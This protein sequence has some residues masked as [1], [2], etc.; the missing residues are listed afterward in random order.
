MEQE[1]IKCACGSNIQK[2]SLQAH[3]KSKKHALFL[4]NPNKFKI[5]QGNYI[6]NFN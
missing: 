5:V 6:I 4:E 2:N 1:K 3:I